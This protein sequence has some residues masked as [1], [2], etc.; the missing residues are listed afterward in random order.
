MKTLMLVSLIAFLVAFIYLFSFE[1]VTTFAADSAPSV[2]LAVSGAG[3]PAVPF[4]QIDREF[5]KKYPNE[6]SSLC[7][8][9]ASK[10]RNR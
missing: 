4:K 10:W 8:A 5:M 3:T 2:K 9:A 7:S 1:V 6:T